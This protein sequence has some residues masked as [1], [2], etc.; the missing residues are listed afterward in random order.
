MLISIRAIPGSG[1]FRL[2]L[3]KEGNPKVYLKNK[4]EANLANMELLKE[5]ARLLGS[6]VSIVRGKDSRRKVLEANISPDEWE[7]IL[8]SLR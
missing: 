4:A 3:D 5:M 1:S 8:D 2:T 7:S 6:E